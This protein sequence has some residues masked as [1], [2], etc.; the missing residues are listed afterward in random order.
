[1]KRIRY[2]PTPVKA[3]SQR[4]GLSASPGSCGVPRKRHGSLYIC[5][6]KKDDR[7][8]GNSSSNSIR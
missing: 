6:K 2:S 8:S 1:M 4:K 3:G 7:Y 5:K